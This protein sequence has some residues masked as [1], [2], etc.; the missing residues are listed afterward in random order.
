VIEVFITGTGQTAVGEHWSISLRHLAWEA[1][2]LALEA[3]QLD[4]PDAIF[5]GNML[6]A[7]ISQ[8]QNLGTLLADF[9]GM[10]GTEAVT[11]E[12]AGASGGAAMR[13]ALLA[14]RSGEISTALVVGVEKMTDK[15]GADVTAAV[16]AGA[17]SDWEQVHGTTPAAIAAL[18]MR[19][20]MH[21]HGVQ[22]E[23]FAEFAINAHCNARTNPD[24]MFRD[25]LDVTRYAQAGMVA[26]PVNAFDT[27]PD[28]DGAAAMI[29]AALPGE[30]QPGL[31]VRV[32]ASSL[33]TDALAVHD[34]Q[35]VLGFTAA[36]LSAD[37]ALQQ[38]GIGTDQI[39][40]AELYDRYS[41]YAALSLE[42]CGFARRGAGWRLAANGAIARAGRLPISTFGGLKARGNPGG[43]TGVYQIVEVARQLAGMAEDNQVDG[44]KWGMAQCLGSSG[45]TAITHIM[46]G[47]ESN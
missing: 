22:L 43:A 7:R 8:Q 30:M 25:V 5:V 39:D 18:I 33:A 45:A 34:R 37:R 28:A 41:V 46:Q 11:V 9:C 4:K 20:Y 36:K 10:R 16:A 17:D 47:I 2:E 3:A 31:S 1:I 42:A 38:A 40:L 14:L 24:A 21:E 6:A 19:R 29:L 44:V 12:A 32:A 27:A 15:V 23:Q 13:Q 26:S 35:D